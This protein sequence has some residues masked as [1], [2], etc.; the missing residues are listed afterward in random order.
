MKVSLCTVCM[1]RSQH[2]KQTLEKNILDNETYGDTEFILIDYNSKDDLEE[3]VKSTL[4]KYIE[5]KKLIYYKTKAPQYFNR[6]HSRNIAFKLATGDIICNVDADNF[7]GEGFAIFLNTAFTHNKGYFFYANDRFDVIGRI[8]FT[9]ESFYKVGGFDEKMV[10]YGFEDSDFIHRLVKSGLKPGLIKNKTYLGSLSHS[11][12]DRMANEYVVNNYYKIFISYKSYSSSIVLVLFKD[13]VFFEGTL[14]NRLNLNLDK[15]DLTMKPPQYDYGIEENKW[16]KGTWKEE[17]SSFFFLTEQNRG[18]VLN[19]ANENTHQYK[20]GGTCYYE[21]VDP[22]LIEDTLF[23]YS[24]LTNRIIFENNLSSSYY[25]V[26]NGEFGKDIVY[27]NFT[28]TP[29]NI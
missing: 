21:L 4:N 8:A 29:I 15:P 1:N 20:D 26:N 7:T 2:I 16:T 3:Y 22:V 27:K 23:F 17:G 6:S 9:R 14:I 24:Q 28:S 13:N 12:K 25:E 19:Y 11:N 10:Y 5:S 18:K